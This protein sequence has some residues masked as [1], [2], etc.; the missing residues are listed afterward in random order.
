MRKL[1]LALLFFCPD[2]CAQQVEG[3]T[4][5]A[6]FVL[7]QPRK[8]VHAQLGPP[9]ERSTNAEGWVYE[10]HKL[11]P[12]TSVYALFKYNVADTSKIY[13]I[14]LVGDPY[15]AMH[16]FKGLRLGDKKEKVHAALGKFE[17]TETVDDPPVTTYYYNN[18]NY[19]VDIDDKG[20]LF[21]IQIFGNILEHK[22]VGHP[23]VRHFKEAV[24][25]KNID[26]LV[27][28]L[29]PDVELH[30]AGKILTYTVGA[31]AELANNNS[32][33]TRLLLG[34]AGSA[35][36]A[37]AKEYAEGT[38]ESRLHPDLNQMIIVDKFFD[39]NTIS[40]VVFRTHAGKW[41]VYEIFFRN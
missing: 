36:Y 7:G 9:F 19:S 33:F 30:K 10:F 20:L 11:K 37:F 40:E 29:A 18:E 14:E 26:S 28:W 3:E 23:S 24:V 15:P 22:P 31:R 27:A 38:S 2:L 34:E 21:G 13:A 5:L 41:K 4:E 32:D 25:K 6:G 16:P 8:N 39:S 12:D 17:R 1:A 35:W